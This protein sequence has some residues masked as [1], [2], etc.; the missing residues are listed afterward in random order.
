MA[1][2]TPI[3]TAAGARRRLQLQSPATLE[4]IGDLEV[5]TAADVHAAL[6]AARAAQPA[7]AA[8]PVEERARYMWRALEILLARQDEYIETVRRESGKPR[9]DALMIE[10]WAGCDALAY[11]AKRAAKL[12][13]PERRRLHGALALMKRLELLYRPLGV[14]GIISP[15]NGPFILSLNPTVQALMAGNAVLLKPSEVTPYSGKLVGDLFEEAGLPPGVLTVLLG[16]GETGAALVEA[17]VDKIS[18]T[19]SV[20]TGRRVAEACA[21]QLL[22]CT[23]E[24]G[25]KDP[26]IVCA[27][28]NLEH[29]SGGAVAGA[30]L[31]SGQVCFSTERV[32]V[33][34]DVADEFV[35]RVVERTRALRQGTGDEYEIGPIFWPRQLE[36]I[37]AHVADAVAKG[38]TVLTGGR[39]HPGLAGL[40]YEP[41]VLTDVTHD[42]LIM[43]EETFGPVLPIMRVRD[44]T[45]ALRYANDTDYGLGATV[46]SRDTRR[47]LALGARINSGSVCVNDMTMTYGALEAPF[48][49]R[50]ASGVGHVNGDAGLRGYCYQQ[51]LIVD[52]FGGRQTASHYP[53][54]AQKDAGMQKFMRFLWGTRLGRRFA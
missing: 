22:P 33:V 52:R 36:I 46:W 5:A 42:M 48:G 15:W 26:M 31:N 54:S 35:R 1:I 49:G 40:Y 21:K 30:F 14:I 8:L 45:E 17:G 47:A 20:G 27:D 2:V 53:Y 4:P 7:W 39:R 41:T 3:E 43:R 51:A 6:T 10:I 38:A 32:Y 37:E 24:L 11:Y 44:E 29:A 34:A 18:F 25:G 23:L 19:G 28:A 9:T 12:L 50:K 16:D 13:R